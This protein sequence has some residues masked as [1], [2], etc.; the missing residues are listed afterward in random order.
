MRRFLLASL[1]ASLLGMSPLPI[2]GSEAWA[3]R[4]R[5]SRGSKAKAKKPSASKP[6]PKSE[7]KA[8]SDP[9]STDP[10][11]GEASSS[12][13][14]SAPPPSRGPARIDFD[15]RLIQGQTN[16]SGAVYLYDRKE[17]KTRSM[18]KERESFRSETLSTVY[19]Q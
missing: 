13:S 2:L 10:V 6:A 11:T 17:L 15:D 12:A 1:V 14:G 4:A 16:K 5:S 9:A 3:Q 7:S 18:I 8:D 19:D